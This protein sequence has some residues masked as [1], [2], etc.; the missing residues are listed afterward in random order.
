MTEN[1]NNNQN[2]NHHHNHHV[3]KRLGCYVKL[4]SGEEC[5]A[6]QGSG[7]T[8]MSSVKLMVR[9]YIPTNL[10]KIDVWPEG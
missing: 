4:S 9:P 1:G 10:L 3:C 7:R 2:N 6:S 8:P 5:L